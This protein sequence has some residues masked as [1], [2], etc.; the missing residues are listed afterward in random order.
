M[1][2]GIDT[3][4]ICVLAVVSL[5]E[6]ILHFVRSGACIFNIPVITVAC[7]MPQVTL[8]LGR[9]TTD[10]VADLICDGGGTMQLL[11]CIRYHKD[12]ITALK[13][14]MQLFVMLARTEKNVKLL[15]KAKALDTL[16]SIQ[17]CATT[18]PSHSDCCECTAIKLLGL[19]GRA[20]G[21]ADTFSAGAR[22]QHRRRNRFAAGFE[23][24]QKGYRTWKSWKTLF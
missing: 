17:V 12:D 13:N 16:K 5:R 20:H 1:E 21:G 10:Y 7:I 4:A 11:K 23:R 6:T 8:S 22:K 18:V 24:A 2:K 15:N 3:P 9:V 14:M 19:A